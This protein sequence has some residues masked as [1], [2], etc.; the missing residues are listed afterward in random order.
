[1]SEFVKSI[2][3]YY[4]AFTETR[5]SNKSTLNYK[6][7]DDPNLTLDLSFLP[8]FFQLWISKLE[9]HDLSPIEI[10]N[11]EYK[12]EIPAL[13]FRQKVDEL[14]S[15]RFDLESLQAAVVAEKMG[16]DLTT[17]EQLREVFLEG[18]RAFNL[19]LRKATEQVIHA[20]QQEEIAAIE[21]QFRANQ[22]PPP[23][24][25]TPKFSQ[26]IYDALQEEA[27]ESNDTEEYFPRVEARLRK[28]AQGIVLYDLFI[29]L[30]QFAVMGSHG[31]CYLFFGSVQ[32]AG[33]GYP[34]FFI[35]VNVDAGAADRVRLTLPRDLVM[36]NTPA[37][38]SFDF[39]NVLTLP[40]AASFTGSI[41]HL[42]Q[43]DSFLASE[44]NLSPQTI[45]TSE[46]C[47]VPPPK[48]ELP[49]LKYR[50]GLQVIKHEDKRVLDYSELMTR[51]ET[52]KGSNI[53]DFVDRYLKGE[54]VSTYDHTES[55]FSDHYPKNTPRYFYSDNPLPLNPS[56]KKILTALE[57]AKNRI[58]VVVGPPGT[59]KSHTIA[60]IT[61]W[62]N[63][64]GKS[65]LITS[66]KQQALDVVE[67][68]LTEKFKAL[69]PHAK[70]P[71]IRIARSQELTTLNTFENS[72]SQP[73]IDGAARRTHDFN[74]E[75]IARDRTRVQESLDQALSS[76]VAHTELMPQMHRKLFRFLQLEQ[77]LAVDAAD[78][79][80]TLSSHLVED[81]ER[82][83]L[84]ANSGAP[85]NFEGLSLE[86]L[87][88]L[89]Q[90]RHEIPMILEACNLVNAQAFDQDVLSGINSAS[91]RNT[92]Q[93]RLL[94]AQLAAAVEPDLPLKELQVVVLEAGP[95]AW[96]EVVSTFKELLA[97]DEQLHKLILLK[98]FRSKL[99][100]DKKYAAAEKAFKDRFPSIWAASQEAGIKPDRL[101]VE[102]S[103]LR[104]SIHLLKEGSP[105]HLEFVYSL[106]RHPADFAG[107]TAA[108][109]DLKSLKFD[110]ILDAISRLA[111]K[112][113]QELTLTDLEEGLN[114][115]DSL[116]VYSQ[117]LQKIGD[118]QTAVGLV[119][120]SCKNLY[121]LLDRLRDSLN[122]LEAPT[123]DALSS[124][125]ARYGT[126]L[127][128]IGIDFSDLVSLTRLTRLTGEEQDLVELVTL[129]AELQ[130]EAP[131]LP[132]ISQ[133]LAELHEYNQRL[134]EHANDQRLKDFQNHPSDIERIK[135]QIANGLRLTGEQAQ[136]LCSTYPCIIAE[137]E[138]VFRFFPMEEGLIDILVFDEASQV[139]IAH[140]L[141]LIL[142]AKQVVV[143]GDQYQY[144]AVGAVNVSR[145]YGGAYFKRIIDDYIREYRQPLSEEARARLLE[146]ETRN[147][148]DDDLIVN[149]T[150][151][152]SELA[153]HKEWIRAFGIRMSTL[154]FCREMRNYHSS[155]EE[156]FRSFPEIIGY[157][158]QFFYEKAQI[159]LV[160]NRLRTKPIGEVLRFIKVETQGHSGRNVNLDE[161]EAIRE[162]IRRLTA[163]GFKGTIG[164]ITSF[165]EQRMRTE[166][167]LREK[168]PDFH[169]L[170]EEHKLTVWFVGDVQGEERDIVYYSF[171]QDKKLDNADLR[172]IYPTPGGA[173]DS[174][175]TLKMQRLNVGFSRAKDTMVLV[176]SMALSD[177]ADTR[178]G[179]ALQY[180][181]N[182]LQE[183]ARS[184][185]FIADE[186]IFGSPKEKDLYTL[187]T[188]TDFFQQ[189]RERLRII[190]QFDL[191]QYIRHEY[192]KHIP[193]YRVDFLLTLAE[194]GKENSLILEYDGLEYHTKDPSM[195][196][197][198]DDFKEEYL[199]YDIRRQLELESYGYHFLR[200][201]KYTLLPRAAG[202]TQRDVLDDLLERAFAVKA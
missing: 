116:T 161:I 191:G 165:R 67:R 49:Y 32:Q 35:E 170:K 127:Q 62:A 24:F 3:N 158:N 164:I 108:L 96:Q 182:V 70:P 18:V 187:I 65:L 178:L 36:L 53:I 42:R 109:N 11:Q 95:N 199:E 111:K 31:S 34:L 74:R 128:R 33:P 46:T 55:T 79:A 107:L 71:V 8:D 134:T 159:P 50:F 139:S 172:S 137:P 83:T 101:V 80:G 200:I 14:L 146:D 75:A 196:R 1:M 12:L 131:F 198:L 47:F 40:R 105:Y 100:I 104:D 122:S 86:S 202:E 171:V 52:G 66:H 177:Y 141:S 115:I 37:I 93:C 26:D 16:K 195:V 168:L 150:I 91:L 29:L 97:V 169:R 54:V 129:H 87:T 181:W 162:D 60:A 183:M 121:L 30:K 82:F 197:S 73:A 22:L 118:F 153:A 81:L 136:L 48:E 68:M 152:D 194:G 61:Y 72:L 189:H 148:I 147:I 51:I 10:S 43:L 59:G 124:V 185:H 89:Y 151:R 78:M 175:N 63:Q 112:D 5:F 57:N 156:H 19:A 188:Q 27:A 173:A 84:L 166:R 92:S 64:N 120:L 98:T 99:G 174:I 38:N 6:W 155:L 176:H 77:E 69:H 76:A 23:T 140:S 113:R 145:K 157:S 28:S 41:A 114:Q 88:A 143:F 132:E 142:R 167:H 154:D 193:R 58:V 119:G 126:P 2:L 103:L 7:L 133:K 85:A 13:R 138:A 149:E 21:T 4:A 44:Y 94:V 106:G 130:R 17:P 123:V 179:D 192:Q 160:A 90:H 201:N 9:K 45:T 190:P 102:I 39:Q 56:Q 163:A 15:S 25:N 144:G 186:T 20:L 180:Y 125:R 184:D 117:H 135:R 110:N